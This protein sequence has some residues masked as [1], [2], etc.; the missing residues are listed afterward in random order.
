[1]PL[2]KET[3]R[4]KICMNYTCLYNIE[5]EWCPQGVVAKELDYDSK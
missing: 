2:N 1:M 5:I 3:K 4:Y